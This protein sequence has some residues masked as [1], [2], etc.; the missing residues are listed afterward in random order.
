MSN[1]LEKWDVKV[2]CLVCA[3]SK[4]VWNFEVYCRKDNMIQEPV[5]NVKPNLT[6]L[7]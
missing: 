5:D 3:S 2:W 1:K 6:L 7:C 4:Y